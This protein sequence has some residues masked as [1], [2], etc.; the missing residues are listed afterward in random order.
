MMN[1]VMSANDF[2]YS[3]LELVIY[4]TL[5]HNKN[6]N[7]YILT[8]NIALQ[9]EM[10]G[11]KIYSGIQQD[12][13]AKLRQIV[14]YLD[15][16]SNITFIDCAPYYDKYLSGSANENSPFTPYAALRLIIDKALPYVDDILYFDCDI[17]VLG[18]FESMYYE[19]R[20]EKKHA[21]Y[22]VYAADAEH[23]EGEMVS[24]VMFFNLDMMRN[25]GFLD[26]ARHNYME[27]EY[28][29]PD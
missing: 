28:F 9:D 12:E 26:R 20:N 8:M 27:N 22:A 6:I 16:N 17:G 7:W 14:K 3:G 13:Q 21:V 29:Y 10:G 1:I 2:V 15:K 18:N 19:C 24:G 23:Y 5:S 11:M 4:S 25:N